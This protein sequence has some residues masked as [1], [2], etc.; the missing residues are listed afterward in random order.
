MRL[1]V[2]VSIIYLLSFFNL[3]SQQVEVE[4][5]FKNFA[6]YYST[7]DLV[8]AEKSLLSI[9]NLKDSIPVSYLVAVYNNLGVINNLFGKYSEAIFYLNQAQNLV[10][11]NNNSAFELADI[12]I[13]KSRIFGINKEYNSAINYLEKGLQI[14]LNIQKKSNTLFFRVSTVYLNLG[15]TYYEKS[16][17]TN[18]LLYLKK[19]ESLKLK[20]NLSEIA[21]SY[22]NLAK[23]YVKLNEKVKA[24]DYFKKSIAAFD[25]EFGADYYRVT[26]VL[27]DY[28][29]FL[30]SSG[31]LTE[32]LS[33]HQKA[34][35]ICLKNYGTKH[36]F[37]SLA[38]KH[39]GDHYFY[40][41][42][43]ATALRYYQQSLI[44]IVGDFNNDDI[45]QN[46]SL[47]KVIF[48]IRLLDNLKSKARALEM[49]SYQQNNPVEKK[50]FLV[51]CLE[52][53]ELALQLVDR[54][55]SDYN[56]PDSRIY[57]AEHEKE[58]YLYA[59]QVA[60]QAYE[61]TKSIEY[62][63]KMYEI[64]CMSKSAVLRNEIMENELVYDQ[65]KPDSTLQ[66]RKKVLLNISSYTKLINDEYQKPKPDTIKI[67]F[68]KDALFEL[69]RD[70][71]RLD[72]AIKDLYP[73][74][75]NLYQ[76]VNPARI[77]DIQK[78]LK[79]DETII[80]YLASNQVV[81]GKRD[82]YI[83]VVSRN[84]LNYL[85][86]TLDSSFS[87]NLGRINSGINNSS[88]YQYTQYVNALYFM[89][90]KL[91][92]PIEPLLSGSRLIVIP[93]E[94]LNYLPFEAFVALEPD[95]GQ[96]GFDQLQ[97]LIYRYSITYAYSS[98]LL[99]GEKKGTIHNPM[100]YAFAPDYR[101]LKN[102]QNGED[103]EMLQGARN[104]IKSI[105]Q[106]FEVT[107]FSDQLSTKLNYINVA[108]QPR[109]FHLAM[110]SL[111]DSINPAFSYLLFLN[112]NDSLEDDKLYNYEIS[113][114][115]MQSPM[116]V[117]SACNTG[118]GN[119]FSGEGVI[120]LTRGFFLAGALSVVNTLWDVNDDAGAKVITGF[121]H[122]LS[123]GEEK[124]VALRMAK[125]DYLKNAPPTYSNPQYWAAYRVMGDKSPVKPRNTMWFWIAG[126][127]I[128]VVG[129]SFYISYKRKKYPNPINK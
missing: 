107:D 3:Y 94:E 2:Y 44:A 119:L 62:L 11:F 63:N 96:T 16:D 76:K 123:R 84:R 51:S 72:Q 14:Y 41:N 120:S 77:A 60:R 111:S 13:N 49:L 93:D 100:V 71:D 87:F 21:L 15:L 28:G 67:A 50:N 114:S 4:S 112:S 53:L 122:Y 116:V 36:P 57:L 78:N 47:T 68:W 39:L 117:L 25:K 52:T 108:N 10:L 69:N 29:L 101:N 79:R 9:L 42:D 85:K 92:K 129:Y 81:E 83:F 88:D 121:Y 95:S 34:L 38:Y 24:E 65:E 6:K 56:S 89:Y 113:L 110:H 26:S 18:A 32:A 103:V 59:V 102:T 23:V 54:I 31:R 74:L 12:Y 109:I 58:T 106:W 98:S 20:Y 17:Y 99:W 125:L 82:L 80:E 8:L 115:R 55:R 43:F 124:G 45:S 5:H 40:I 66:N 105:N 118:T 27:F 1:R 91:V 64:T 46:P 61:L 22:L 73:Q 127:F 126:L 104:E 97:Y 70:K 33:V 90:D 48:N 128:A 75:G 30:R 19:S 35:S 37:V 7:G 86:T